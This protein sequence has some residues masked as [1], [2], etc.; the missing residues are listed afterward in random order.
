MPAALLSTR[1]GAT[2]VL[3]LSH[4]ERHNALGPEFWAAG[5]EALSV[6]ESSA[7][8]A[9]VVIAGAGALFSVGHDLEQ[10][11]ASRREPASHQVALT[12]GLHSWVEAIRSFPKPVVAAVEGAASDAGFALALACDFIVAGRSAQF[13]MASGVLGLSPD[14]GA[15]WSLARALPRQLASEMLMLGTRL[16]AER[17]HTLGVVNRL[18]APGAALHEALALTEQLN[19][20]APHALASAKEL[21]ADAEA[22]TLPEQLAR[23]RDHFVANLHHASTGAAIAAFRQQ[24]GASP[25]A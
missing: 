24:R 22:A 5:V 16:G 2:M 6:A 9:S 19:A 15:S 23:E 13:A 14:G 21:L 3:T 11:L 20:R 12:E 1:H 17:L 8:V 10:L 18:C 7:E 25:I 4:P